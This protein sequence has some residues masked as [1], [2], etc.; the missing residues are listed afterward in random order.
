MPVTYGIL[1]ESIL[2]V[3]EGVVESAE[4]L[5]AQH[6]MFNDPAF[7]GT[8]PRLIDATGVTTMNFSSGIVRHVA[9]CAEERG[10]R[11]AALVSNNQDFVHGMMRLYAEYT[12]RAEVEVFRN[13]EAAAAWLN[14]DYRS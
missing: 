5:E 3:L 13:R 7:K 4:L 9:R 8:Y 11:R 1:D 2:I 12:G 6:A 14:G 10:L